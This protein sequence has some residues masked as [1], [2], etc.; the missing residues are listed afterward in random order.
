[1]RVVKVQLA[2]ALTKYLLRSRTVTHIAKYSKVS[3]RAGFCWWGV[4]GQH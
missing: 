1:M 4:R 2:C 3:H